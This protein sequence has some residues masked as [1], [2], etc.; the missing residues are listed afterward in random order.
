ME[1]DGSI[2]HQ[3]H[4]FNMDGNIHVGDVSDLCFPC[5]TQ[6]GGA[7]VGISYTM[8]GQTMR[9]TFFPTNADLIQPGV[10]KLTLRDRSANGTVYRSLNLPDV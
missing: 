10:R 2:F 1:K 6:E 8:A 3:I 9:A 7:I 4:V 5:T